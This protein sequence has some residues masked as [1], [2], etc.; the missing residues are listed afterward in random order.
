MVNVKIPV[1][2]K[3]YGTIDLDYN[4]HEKLS[5]HKKRKL[6]PEKAIL[7]FEDNS[8]K[9]EVEFTKKQWKKFIKNINKVE[10][11]AKEHY[12]AC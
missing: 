7:S 6:T 1:E 9:V 10:W 12:G 5:G 8:T 4:S 2:R 3:C 11:I